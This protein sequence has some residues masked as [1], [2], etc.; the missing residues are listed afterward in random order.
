MKAEL[1][2]RLKTTKCDAGES[3]GSASEIM[4]IDAFDPF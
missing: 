3:E 1:E 2:N 4:E